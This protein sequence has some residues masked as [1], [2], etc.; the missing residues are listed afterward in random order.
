MSDR[1]SERYRN[2]RLARNLKTSDGAM[3]LDEVI[4]LVRDYTRCHMDVPGPRANQLIDEIDRLRALGDALA[5]SAEW[6]G[7]ACPGEFPALEDKAQA[8]RAGR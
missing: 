2:E 1:D 5:E 6:I 8:W 4:D 3:S 7:R